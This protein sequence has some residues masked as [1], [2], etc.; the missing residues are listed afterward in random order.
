MQIDADQGQA[1]L[2]HGL[3]H[4]AQQRDRVLIGEVAQRGAREEQQPARGR[5]VGH[6]N[7]HR[8]GEVGTHRQHFHVRQ[9]RC[10]VVDAGQQRRARDLDGRVGHRILQGGQQAGGLAAAATAQFHHMHARPHRLRDLRQHP[11]QQGQLG[12]CG[13]VLAGVGDLLEQAR[14]A[15]V[16]EVFGR[17]L[18]RGMR[19]PRH[20]VGKDLLAA[21]GKVGQRL[22]RV[23][24]GAHERSLARRM[25]ENCQ[26]AGGM[27]KLR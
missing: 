8:P 9:R 3:A 19:Q 15:R 10:Q 1:V 25:P 6:G 22:Q 17:Q 20:G 23:L 18:A 21:G 7:L 4:C 2:A 12:A 14:A 13:V 24:D 26:R 16:V 11:I 5:P 27:K